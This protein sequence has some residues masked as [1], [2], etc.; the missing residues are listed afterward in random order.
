MHCGVYDMCGSKLQDNEAG[1][2]ERVAGDLL[3][4]ALTVRIY[5]V[6]A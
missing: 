6:R 3:S 2:M 5:I 4:S 1:A